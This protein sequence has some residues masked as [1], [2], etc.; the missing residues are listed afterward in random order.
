VRPD[1]GVLALSIR[2]GPMTIEELHRRYVNRKNLQERARYGN[3]E[4]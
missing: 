1:E 3:A 4:T 2:L